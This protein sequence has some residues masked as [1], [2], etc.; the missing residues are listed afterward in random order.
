MRALLGWGSVAFCAFSLATGAN[1]ATYSLKDLAN[2]TV[3]SITSDDGKL[4][5]SD[6]NVTRVKKL[7]NDLSLY[8]VETTTDGIILTSSEFDAQSGGM[9][10]LDLTYTVSAVAGTI[11]GAEMEMA[12]SRQ[13]GRVKVEKDIEAHDQASDAGTF[14]VTVLTGGAS[15]LLD[16]DTFS[17]GEAAFDVEEQIRIKKVATLSSVRNS[18]TV[19]PEP[20]TLSLLLVGVG[21]LAVYGRRRAL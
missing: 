19:V 2:G 16:S 14:L 21:G 11:T 13:S 5:F 17:S 8:T 10:K 9:K 3:A 15:Q 1:A 4:T 20:A 18:F 12:A 7:S 6:F